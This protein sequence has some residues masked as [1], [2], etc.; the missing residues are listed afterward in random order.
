MVQYRVFLY[1]DVK[2]VWFELTKGYTDPVEAGLPYEIEGNYKY[3]SGKYKVSVWVKNSESK[4]NY[5]SYYVTELNCIKDGKS[6][7]KLSGD[8][9]IPSDKYGYGVSITIDGINNDLHKANL[10]KYKLHVYDVKNKKWIKDIT[11]YDRNIIWTPS[12]PGVYVIDI[13][14]ISWDSPL[15]VKANQSGVNAYEGWKLKVI[16]VENG[17]YYDDYSISRVAGQY[18]V[19]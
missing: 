8:V 17:I 6:N 19:F 14:A 11:S 5:D 12:K 4:N 18:K 16:T 15:A 10:Y 9:N 3:Q 2:K 1:S 7:V 13:W